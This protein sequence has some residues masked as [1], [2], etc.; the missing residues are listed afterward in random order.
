MARTQ[1]PIRNLAPPGLPHSSRTQPAAWPQERIR[2]PL[3]APICAAL[4]CFIFAVGLSS[5]AAD[6]PIAAAAAPTASAP[7]VSPPAEPAEKPA[8]RPEASA[9]NPKSGIPPKPSLRRSRFPDPRRQRPGRPDAAPPSSQVAAG[10]QKAC[11]D[12]FQGRLQGEARTACASGASTFVKSGLRSSQIQCRLAF[13]ASAPATMACLIG[14]AIAEDVASNRNDFALK[15]AICSAHYP[16]HTEVDSYL[17]QSC[18]AGIYLPRTL[19]RSNSGLC[20]DVTPRAFV[21]RAV[22]NRTQPGAGGSRAQS[23]PTAR[24]GGA[25]GRRQ[26]PDS[27]RR[28]WRDGRQR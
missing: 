23:R 5:F 14:A 2:K 27:E 4:G 6:L 24:G 3:R 22:Q 12:D 13:G 8:D 20:R 10:A 11:N 19:G 7:V 1:S 21:Y 26:I 28:D 15:R 9:S 25:F 16:A 18:L 17:Q